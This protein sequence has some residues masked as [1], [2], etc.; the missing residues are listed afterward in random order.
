M[1]VQIESQAA[2]AEPGIGQSVVQG[3][4]SGVAS[5][6][7]GVISS[8]FNT[9]MNLIEGNP[10]TQSQ[11]DAEQL[12]Q[13]NALDQQQLG[14]NEQMSDYGEQEQQK[15]WNGTNSL[16]L[17]NEAAQQG[18]NSALIYGG[19]GA[20]GSTGS[21][22]VT[23]SEPQAADSA[24]IGQ[25]ENQQQANMQ[26]AGAA[27]A[28]AAATNANI[29]NITATTDNITAET[30]LLAQQTNNQ[31]LAAQGQ[32]LQ[33]TYQEIQNKIAQHTSGDIIQTVTQNLENLATQQ[34]QLMSQ[35]AGQDISNN[36]MQAAQKTIIATYRA[37]LINIVT[38]TL[39]QDSEIKVNDAQQKAIIEGIQQKW[40]EIDT[41]HMSIQQQRDNIE[42]MI[43]ANHWD[44]A[45]GA[46]AQLVT[47]VTLNGLNTGTTTTS[48]MHDDQGNSTYTKSTTKPNN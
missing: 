39:K 30:N 7:G 13:Q 5:G 15:L 42:S 19:M 44:K 40:S 9:G 23:M 16:A 41:Q 35:I 33:N 37:Q 47:G 24:A 32:R 48:E 31:A 26:N 34:K 25:V 22:A 17:A 46:A 8:L 28:Q 14:Y 4:D 38:N 1:P 6:I 3:V 2:A 20:G 21:G 10:I 29:K 11:K 36:T 12:K 43:E 45:L 18:Y 27:A